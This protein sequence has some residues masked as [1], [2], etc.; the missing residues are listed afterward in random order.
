MSEA[1]AHGAHHEETHH[2]PGFLRKYIFSTDH[3]TI[4]I[5]FLFTGLIMFLL[6]GFLAMGVRWQ[7]AWPYDLPFG[8]PFPDSL[9]KPVTLPDGRT[10]HTM[11]G[12]FYTMLVSMH[13]SVMIFMVVI[14]LLTGAFGNYL[15]PLQIGARDM[16]FPTLNMFSYWLFWPG[17]I[18][19]LTGFFAEGGHAAAGWTS[20]PPLSGPGVGEGPFTPGSGIGQT[21]WLISLIIIGTSSIMGA[22]NYITTIVKLRAPGMGFFRMPLSVWALFITAILVVFGTP[23]LTSALLMLLLDRTLHTSFF[24][25][26]Q[27]GQ[28]LL[29]QHLFWFYSHPAVYI[30]ILPGMGMVSDI[31]STFA[32]KPIFGY[33][34]MVFSLMAIAGLGFIVWGHHMFQSGM[35]PY[36]GTTFMIS[37]TMIALPSAIKTFNWLGTLWQSN[38]KLSVPMLHAIAFVSMFIIGGLSGI[39]MASTPVDIFLH[40]TYY[41]VGHIHYV[42]FGGSMFAIF[43]GINYWFPKMFGRMMNKPLG[44]IHFVLTFILFNT[45]FFPMHIIGIAGHPRRYAIAWDKVN[46]LGYHFLRDIQPW[47]EFI[48]HSALTLGAVQIL[49]IINFFYSLFWGKR[50]E[51]NP[52]K[53]NTLEWAAAPSPP[54]HGNWGAEI[55]VVH[56]GP[57]EYAHPAA[58]EDYLPQNETL[59]AR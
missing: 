23:V 17:A 47:N 22:V 24:Q 50:A 46:E 36:L 13:A 39:Y 26:H 42:L 28:P 19:M 2:D 11:G 45:T 41:I 14:P 1:T 6:G 59:P 56:R 51:A 12:E 31:I 34:P 55:P 21:C 58:A 29:W 33:K 5:Q 27:G 25:P 54:P 52:W 20:Y 38:M 48:T 43:A 3:K 4:G 7:L 8:E 40:D 30:M 57:Y 10:I 44:Y 15:I 16:A 49:F 35:S 18:I 37:T 32:R 53:A 9:I